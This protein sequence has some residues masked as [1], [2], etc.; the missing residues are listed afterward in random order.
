[1][2]YLFF[3]FSYLVG[4]L[5]FAI[6]ISKYYHLDDPRSFGSKNAGATNVM[7]SGNKKAGLITFLGDALKGTL[8]III[9]KY[10]FFSQ[11]SSEI[12]VSIGATLVILGHIYP[13]YYNFKGGKGV[14]TL[15]GVVLGI[16][17]ILF[18]ASIG[19]WAVA[20]TF[21][22]VSS[23]SSLITLALVPIYSYFIIGGNPYTISMII[24][25]LIILYKHTD[26]IKRLFKKSEHK[27]K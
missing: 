6:F 25:S 2:M 9:G 4:S 26:N 21:F 17:P 7:R 10:I 23:I 20:F 11:D 1:M 12:I 3:I 14:A 22:R 18:L 8:I 5:S 16:N 27:F 15:F 19:S 24:C 13:V